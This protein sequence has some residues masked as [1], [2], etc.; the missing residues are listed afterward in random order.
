MLSPIQKLLLAFTTLIVGLVIVGV[1]A[2]SVSQITS[3][4]SITQTVDISAAKSA[5]GTLLNESILF[6]NGTGT[7]SSKEGVPNIELNNVVLCA[8]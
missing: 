4:S 8:P 6:N 7:P 2:Q 5:S 3:P 1:I